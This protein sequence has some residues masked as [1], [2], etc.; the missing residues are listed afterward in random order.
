MKKVRSF[1]LI[2]CLLLGNVVFSAEVIILHTSDTHGRI[3]PIEYNGV[4]YMGG[5]SKRLNIVQ[6]VRKHNKNV[7]LLDSGDYFQ[8]SI[9]YRIDQGKS[10][11]KLLPDIKYDAIALGNHE[12]DNGIKVLK[13][14]IKNSKTQFLSANVHFKDRYLKKA[15]KPYIIKEFEGEKI[16]IIGVTTS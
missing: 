5:F 7:L 13:R 2:L 3:S 4:N 6:D 1:I 11:A 16:L 15:V 10:I 8:G 12:F 14:N 9:Y